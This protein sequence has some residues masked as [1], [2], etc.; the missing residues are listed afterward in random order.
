ME[1]YAAPGLQICSTGL[2]G[3][4]G[5]KETDGA[6]EKNRYQPFGQKRAEY[7][8]TY[9]CLLYTSILDPDVLRR[10]VSSAEQYA[11]Q[12]LAAFLLSVC[13]EET[14]HV[15]HL[16]FTYLELSKTLNI[17]R[18]SLYRALNSLQRCGVLQRDGHDLFILDPDAVSYT[19]LD[20][21]TRQARGL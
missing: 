6:S 18:A 20:V 14:P 15:Y 5:R 17:G 7:S 11:E 8:G 3:D 19:H 10:I 16:P 12:C 4:D 21:Y 13:P 1:I 9:S 2:R